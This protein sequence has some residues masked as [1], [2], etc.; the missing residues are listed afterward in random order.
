MRPKTISIVLVEKYFGFAFELADQICAVKRGEV[1]CESK[2]FN[3]E[4]LKLRT[5]LGV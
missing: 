3:I 2:K 1:V 4:R 5:S